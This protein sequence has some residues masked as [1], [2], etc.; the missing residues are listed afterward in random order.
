MPNSAS[1]QLNGMVVDAVVVGAGYAGL[2]AA[3]HLADS[4]KSVLVLEGRDRV[5]GRAYSG[6]IAG[7]TVD[8]GATWVAERHTA[9]RDLMSKVGCTTTGQF[10]RGHNT[11][12]MN[13]ELVEYT[14]ALPLGG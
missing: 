5:G 3:A 1:A 14:G 10:D 13:G 11:L 7:V 6:E 8:L 4:G 12:L 2:T 9:V